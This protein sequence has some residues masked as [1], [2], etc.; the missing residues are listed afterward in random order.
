[1][2]TVAALCSCND[3]EGYEEAYPDIVSEMANV[4]TNNEGKMVRMITDD[5]TAYNISN[6]LTGYDR[7]AVYRLVCGYVPSGKDAM[8]YQ[9]QGVQILRDSTDTGK[10]DPTPVTCAWK[11]GKYINLQ[12]EPLTQG[13]RQYWGFVVE[14]KE[15]GHI[16]ISLHHNQNNDP[17]S[18]TRTVYAS[19]PVNSME[20]IEDG[21]QITL[22]VNTPTGLKEWNFQK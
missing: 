6:N 9:L 15:P 1:M 7:N 17:A 18:Y 5:E 11:S 10:Q 14:R 3:E 8:L 21:G 16:Y 4:V 22:Y 20:G 12:L 2:I 13:G 19:L